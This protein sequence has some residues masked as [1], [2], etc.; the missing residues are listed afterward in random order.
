MRPALRKAVFGVLLLPSL[1]LFHGPA[2]GQ[3]VPSAAPTETPAAFVERLQT[4]L[5]SGTLEAYLEAFRPEVRPAERSRLQIFFDDLQMTGVSLRP[6]GVQKNAGGPARVFVQA[7]FEN[8]HAALIESWTLGLESRG[9][10]W[11][12]ARLDVTGPTTRMY[13]VRIPADRAVRARRVEV[14]H[15]DV[16]FTFT[17][18][19][20]FYDNLPNVETA[21]VIVGRG[22]V[23]FTPGDANEKHQL[24]LLYKKDRIEDEVE[25]L[26]VRCAPGVFGSNIV[27]EA[28]GTGAA[29]SAVERDK[30]AAVFARNYPRS[31]T[32]ESSIDG[33][34][35]SFLPQSDEA[36]FEFKARRFGEMVYIYYPF[37][38]EEVS[39]YDHAKDRTICLYSPAVASGT[40]GSPQKRMFL[41]FAE[42]FDVSH[43]TL[44]LSLVPASSYLSAKAL[45][46]VIPKVDLL[47]SLKFRFNPDLEILK[48]AD[49]AGRELFYT[50]DKVRGILYVYFV[51]PPE[52]Q[53]PTSI[54]IYYRGHLAPATPTTDVI[55]Q[56]GS[57]DPIRFRPRYETAF[58][59]HA[60][61]WYPGPAEEDYFPARLTI[62]VP[63]E[64][65]C[66]ANGELVAQG[67]REDMED[68]AALEKAGSAVYTFVSR[69]PVKYLSFIAGKFLPKKER[70]GPVPIS[71]HV[72]TEILDSRP[73]LVDQAADILDFY[74][75]AFGPYPY[76][77]LGIVLRLWPVLGG[78]SPAS[79]IVL[80]EVPWIGNSGFPA[81]LDTPVDLS[82]WDEYFLAHEIAHQWWGQ[83]VSFDSYKDQWLSEGLA[84]FAAASYLRNR[85]GEGAFSS[86]LRKFAR[87]TEKKSF[88]GPILMGS[89][90]S[91]F[92]FTAYQAI[93]YDKAALVLFMLQDLIGPE[94]F[95]A[96]LK[97]FFESHK[98]AAARTAQFFAAMEAASG[99]DLGEFVRGWFTSW[100]LPDVRTT[101]TETAVPEGVRIDVRVTQVKGRFVF[102][103]WVEWTRGSDRGRT[104]IVVDEEEEA[105]SFTLPAK[106]DRI[107]I[108]PDKAVPGKFD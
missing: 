27:I 84:Q 106:P 107:R 3:D 20:V 89:R 94:A 69:A 93:V 33:G 6:A 78:H 29:V 45:I 71:T 105:A 50:V 26:F 104:L 79:F 43:Y 40:E 52:A 70:P 80:N 99:R 28:D 67:R 5:R 31:Y 58:Y 91:Y 8:D 11:S 51:S 13:K 100:E 24:E 108:N 81:T 53:T 25:S 98:Y 74:G 10:A 55:G 44:D 68:V 48:I 88:R 32:I 86:I 95:A 63:P 75:R 49:E 87:W 54:E 16:H 90:L 36:V 47:D 76:E 19:A 102:P 66:V 72:A 37:S 22:R 15:A 34:L 96:G 30:A 61:N 2:A 56:A 21:L 101:W 4:L 41:S 73:A 18:A 1:F 59:S 7:F 12:V 38:G 62:M 97:A 92:D 39:L 17:D 65:R 77:K 60:G 57:G 64:Y 23:S 103:L 85:Y 9:G 83:G 14:R 42:K 46:E 35:L 82:A